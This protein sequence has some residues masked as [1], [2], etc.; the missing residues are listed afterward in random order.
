[1]AR[2][3]DIRKKK[4]VPHS[5]GPPLQTM[6]AHMEVAARKRLRPIRVWPHN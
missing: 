5:A 1:M 3:D 2:A 4:A 6:A